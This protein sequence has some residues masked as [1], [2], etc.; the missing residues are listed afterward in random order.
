MSAAETLVI[1]RKVWTRAEVD[2]FSFD[3]LS[4]ELV[5]GELIDRSM[6]KNPPHIYWLTLLRA[7]FMEQFGAEYV[8]SEDPIDLSPEDNATSEPEP[9]LAVTSESIRE[10]RGVNPGPA[11]LR[12][13]VEVANT[14]YDYD[15]TVK[16][17][18][19]ARA[20]IAE[21]WVLDVRV[22]EIP[23]LLVHRAPVDGAYRD[24]TVRSHTEDVEVL[25]ERHLRLADLM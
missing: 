24:K 13:V 12:L 20:G 18:L 17:A 15:T 9:D 5:N 6:G 25:S 23:R 11:T 7:W 19:Y 2:R 21:Y 16:A 22:I 10:T 1:P 3:G 8:R 4:L 14:T